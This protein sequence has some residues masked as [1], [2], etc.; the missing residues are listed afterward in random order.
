MTKKNKSKKDTTFLHLE[1]AEKVRN[2]Q[3]AVGKLGKKLSEIEPNM[4]HH[5]IKITCPICMAEVKVD[6]P[7]VKLIKEGS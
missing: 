3:I 7:T 1:T 2:L 4:H 6:I 5:D